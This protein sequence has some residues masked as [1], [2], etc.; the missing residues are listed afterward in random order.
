MATGGEA[1]VLVGSEA[2][3]VGA[4]VRA[5][6]GQGERVG[7]FVVTNDQ[8]DSEAALTEMVTELYG[9]DPVR[10]PNT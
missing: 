10:I 5:A 6:T 1:V 7:A 3:D 2:G 8:G 9:T 4:A